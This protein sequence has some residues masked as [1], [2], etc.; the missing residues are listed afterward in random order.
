MGAFCPRPGI[1]AAE[2]FRYLYDDEELRQWIP[3][4]ERLAEDSKEIHLL[5]NNC[6][7]DYGVRNAGDIGRL[8]AEA[9]ARER[10]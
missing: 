4:V 9:G 1:T 6:Y 3:R 7:Q 8:L 5:M 2:R 10:T